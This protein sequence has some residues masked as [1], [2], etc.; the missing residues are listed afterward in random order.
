MDEMKRQHDCVSML[1]LSG[2]PPFSALLWD[3]TFKG[4]DSVY[5]GVD[6]CWEEE[7]EMAP[8]M[9][10]PHQSQLS[11]V[12]KGSSSG[13]Q[14]IISHKHYRRRSLSKSVLGVVIIVLLSN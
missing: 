10:V 4:A 7:V 11:A 2:W 1:F 8:F 3:I 5:S 6:L 14:M 13:A 12:S 9:M